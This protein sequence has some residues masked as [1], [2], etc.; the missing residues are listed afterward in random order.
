MC[1][2]VRGSCFY[3]LL[4]NF[5][6]MVADKCYNI[7]RYG[8]SSKAAIHIT[9]VMLQMVPCPVL[10]LWSSGKRILFVLFFIQVSFQPANF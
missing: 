4:I 5:T 6:Y 2:F 10:P 3:A 7:Y 8:F 1:K 9:L